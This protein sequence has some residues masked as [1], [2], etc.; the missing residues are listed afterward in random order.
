[1]KQDKA[2]IKILKSQKDEKLPTDFNARMMTQIY[3]VSAARKK[4]SMVLSYIL[5]S[6]VSI[7]LILLATYLLK[8]HLSFN[9]SFRIPAS[10]FS[11]QSKTIFGFSVYIASLILLLMFIDR[12][13][14]NMHEKKRMG[15]S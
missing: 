9:F 14:R 15:K 13:F 8:D 7:S 10:F 3:L 1:M 12:F 6:T 5:I 4:R 2:L 11:P